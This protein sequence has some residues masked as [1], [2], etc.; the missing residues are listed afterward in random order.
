MDASERPKAGSRE[1]AG[2][3]PPEDVCRV[4]VTSDKMAV[5]LTC[6]VRPALIDRL[7][8]RIMAELTALGVATKWEHEDLPAWLR[9]AAAKDP[10]LEKE[11]IEEGTRPSPATNSRVEWGGE[12]FKTGFYIDERTHAID[13]RRHVAQRTVSEGQLLAR[14]I[15]GTP[16]SPGKDVFGKEV[17]AVQ[18][19]MPKILVGENVRQEGLDFYATATGRFRWQPK[20][21]TASAIGGRLSV[22]AVYV[23][24]GN[25]GLDTGNISHPGALHVRKDVEEGAEIETEGDIEIDGLVEPCC[26]RTKG[27]LTVRGGITGSSGKRIIVGGSI[28]AR[29]IAEAFVEAEGDVAVEREIRN[30]TVKTRGAIIAPAGHVVGGT[31]MALGGINVG[32]IGSHGVPTTLVAGEDFRLAGEIEERE[33]LIARREEALK[34]VETVLWPLLPRADKLSADKQ[35]ALAGLVA[36]V[37]ENKSA[38]EQLQQ[39][40]EELKKASRARAVFRIEIRNRVHTE[41]SF[42]LRKEWL[43]VQ[44]ELSGP[45]E[46]ILRGNQLV[47]KRVE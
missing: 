38:I 22:D 3:R 45:A 43:R 21:D 15:P 10:R 24:A 17:P 41:T 25:V 34:K 19:T 14:I 2:K 29:F 26:I 9:A 39:E 6:T 44:K 12:F 1:G 7:A 23:I 36:M 18:P 37:K 20:R 42:R 30:C 40:I 5:L 11:V 46:A 4:E 28:H 8:Q 16:G 33:A 35:K 47:L 13:Y 27:N 31:L 32:E